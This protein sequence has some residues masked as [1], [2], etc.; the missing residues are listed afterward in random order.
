VTLAE[1]Q[2]EY[3]AVKDEQNRLY[4]LFTRT[5][6]GKPV[7]ATVTRRLYELEEMIREEKRKMVADYEQRKAQKIER[8]QDRAEKAR[9][10][11]DQQYA[12]AKSMSDCIPFGQPILIGHHSEKRD[13]NFRDKI[14]RKF[15]KSA[16]LHRKAGELES[17]AAAM[18]DNNAIFS[19]DPNCVLKLEEKI[20]KLEKRQSL[21]VAANKLLRVL[22]E[23]KNVGFPAVDV[24]ALKAKNPD[25]TILAPGT[26]VKEKG[27]DVIGKI[28]L[29]KDHG[30]HVVHH[31]VLWPRK[32]KAVMAFLYRL[33]IVGFE[34]IEQTTT[35]AGNGAAKEK[36]KEKARQALLDLGFNEALIAELLKPDSCGRIGF[37]DYKIQNNRANISRLKE[38]LQAEA[39]KASEETSERE[40]NGIRIV[41]NVEE[42]RLQMFFPCKP[43]EKIREELKRKGFRWSPYNKAW[44][45]HRGNNANYAAEVVAKLLASGGEINVP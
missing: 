39:V 7:P 21:M 20:D 43:E 34:A 9:R 4:W 13:R 25:N 30:C 38:R 11:S 6:R 36:A 32:R 24:E 23:K 22:V 8:L 37:P 33:E 12:Q 17:R 15:D 14:G 41:D 28:V 3:E 35:P 44:Q 29:I 26:L 40:I 18:E 27:S 1:L 16:E 10:E 31:Y 42:N 45:R 5:A 19:D 2:A